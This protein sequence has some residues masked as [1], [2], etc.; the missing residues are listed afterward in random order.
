LLKNYLNQHAAYKAKTGTN[1]RG[2]PVYGG[3]VTISCR[4]RKKVQYILTATGQTVKTQHVYYL[5]AAVSEGDMLDGMAVTAVSD[6]TCLGGE[7][8]GY[9]AVL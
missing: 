8:L 5:N 6:W 3:A 1:D 2:Q 7:T 4:K 9:K